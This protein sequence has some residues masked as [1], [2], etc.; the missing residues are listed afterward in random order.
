MAGFESIHPGT[1]RPGDRFG[2]YRIESEVGSGGLATV[3]RAHDDDN[4]VV[5]LKLLDAWSTDEEMERFRREYDAVADL[6][7]PNIV[8]VLET[9]QTH[10]RSWIA[11]E[12]VDGEDLDEVLRR[13]KAQPDSSR[14]PTVERIARGLCKALAHIHDR[15]LIHRDLKPGNILVTAA[16]DPKLS[17]FGVVK[18]MEGSSV[19]EAGRLVGTIAYMAPEQIADEPLDGRTDLYALG[20]V[21]YTMLTLRRPIEA[22]TVHGYLA[23]HL[24]EVPP[25]P[26]ELDPAVPPKLERVAN[27]LL[28]KD[29]KRRYGTARA[30]IRALDATEGEAAQQLYGREALLLRWTRML[31]AGQ[32]GVVILEGPAGSGRSTLMRAFEL[33]AQERGLTAHRLPHR[34]SDSAPVLDGDVLFLD[35]LEDAAPGALTHIER[36]VR[37]ALSGAGPTVVLSQRTETAPARNWRWAASA[38]PWPLMPLR[39]RDL[40]ALLRDRGVPTAPA[41]GLAKRLAETVVA[42]PGALHAL[43]D[44]LIEEGWLVPDVHGLRATR[45]VAAFREEDLPVPAATRRHMESVLTALDADESELIEL[46]AVVGRPV[47]ASL[48]GRCATRPARV[49]STLDRLLEAELLTTVD[50][51][52]DVTLKLVHPLFGTVARRA[53]SAGRRQQRHEAIARALRR[54]RRRGASAREA[55]YHLAEAGLAHEAIPLLLRSARSEARAGRYSKVLRLLERAN[56]L[57]PAASAHLDARSIDKYR[58]DA[59]SLRGSSLLATGR[60][61][62]A[63]PSLE[64]ALALARVNG[65][66]AEVSRALCDLGRVMYRLGRHERARTL[67]TRALDHEGLGEVR[68]GRARR[69]LAD[70]HLQR[71]E[72]D[73]SEELFHEAITEANVAGNRDG[74]ARAR[75]GYANVLGLK[76]DLG[77]AAEQLD[78]AD[79]LLDP[80]GDKRVRSGILARS[81]ELELAAGRLGY[82][83][84]RVDVLVDLVHTHQLSR[85]LPDGLALS[86]QV[87]LAM[88]NEQQAVAEARRAL[89]FSG[90][91]SQPSWDGM[92]RA[93]RVLL[94]TNTLDHDPLA[95]LEQTRL[96]RAPLHDPRG[97]A[98]ALRARIA[99]NTDKLHARDL[100]IESLARMPARWMLSHAARTLDAVH[101]L[102]ACGA[103]DAAIAALDG[104][105]TAVDPRRT[106]GLRLELLLARELARDDSR[107]EE[108]QTLASNV[109]ATLSGRHRDAWMARPGIAMLLG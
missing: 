92:F 65:E 20:A 71:G 31:E 15:G 63:L 76:G 24:T 102:I 78:H 50:D 66:P 58:R 103:N 97:Q 49:P 61:Q 60:W 75:R 12:Y 77:H 108:A 36:A 62:E 32:R 47:G 41:T 57:E 100:A 73:R 22:D 16:G 56:E 93:V 87:H 99:A 21:L 44:V 9:G 39:S 30:V 109:A 85:R 59:L 10:G 14:F 64:E 46:V 88:G 6:E 74:E 45:T 69:A 80:D 67:L 11:L 90:T 96:P 7:H 52:D 5:A 83:L 104:L 38:E 37:N 40:V 72:L 35:D 8:R 51:S 53:M 34:V 54:Q 81:I 19:T 95:T 25:P 101:A 27:R 1:P 106:T 48:I 98:L 26:H 42:H 68:R 18:D 3:Y 4:R 105:M 23:R 13:W 84:H 82:A 29:P 2:R 89:L 55:A 94:S 70:I 86:A 107:R 79:E 43:V 17:D 28:Q 91:Q 33:A